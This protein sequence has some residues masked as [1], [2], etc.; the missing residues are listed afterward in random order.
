MSVRWP[1]EE[2]GDGSNRPL[3]ARPSFL[4]TRRWVIQAVVAAHLGIET[5]E[6]GDGR[7][8]RERHRKK[9]FTSGYLTNRCIRGWLDSLSDVLHPARGANRCLGR[10]SAVTARSG[11][12]ACHP[13]WPSPRMSKAAG[14]RNRS[15]CRDRATPCART[16]ATAL[17][18]RLHSDEVM[19][20]PPWAF[21]FSKCSGG[22]RTHP[23]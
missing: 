19:I 13:R 8:D 7:A 11:G 16:C 15:Y 9:R 17:V 4:S 20:L 21:V 2:S 18:E 10:Y 6:A 22:N 5:W 12:N 23:A 3:A 1:A 14:P